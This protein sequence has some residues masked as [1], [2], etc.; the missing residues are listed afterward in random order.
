MNGGGFCAF[1]CRPRWVVGGDKPL[2]QGGDAK[3]EE[4][5]CAFPCDVNGHRVNAE[6][7]RFYSATVH[8]GWNSKINPKASRPLWWRTQTDLFNARQRCIIDEPGEA[9]QCTTAWRD[10]PPK[11]IC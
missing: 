10:N 8:N 11:K 2:E 7:E 9:V 1:A 3:D 4:V 5:V 6:S